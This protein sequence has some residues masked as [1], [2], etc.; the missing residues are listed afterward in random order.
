MYPN[1]DTFIDDIFRRLARLEEAVKQLRERNLEDDLMAL[2]IR[3][4]KIE[5]QGVSNGKQN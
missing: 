2:K 1:D 4:E 5:R 3:I